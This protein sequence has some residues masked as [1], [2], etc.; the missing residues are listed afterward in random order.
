[1]CQARPVAGGTRVL[2]VSE[3]PEEAASAAVGNEPRRGRGASRSGASRIYCRCRTVEPPPAQ[4]PPPEPEP[5]TPMSVEYVMHTLA[6][7]LPEEAVVFDEAA[8]SKAEAPQVH[9]P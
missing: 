6:S 5:G 1:M 4:E 8:S 3:D 7:V 9:P 2:H